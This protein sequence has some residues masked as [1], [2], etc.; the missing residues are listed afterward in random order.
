[1]RAVRRRGAVRCAMHRRVERSSTHACG[2]VEPCSSTLLAGLPAVHA[3]L[4][5]GK[6]AGILVQQPAPRVS[7]FTPSSLLLCVYNPPFITNPLSQAPPQRVSSLF[8]LARP[9][10]HA[11]TVSEMSHIQ[12][13]RQT[14]CAA[15]VAGRSERGSLKPCER[16]G[17]SNCNGGRR[18]DTGR[19]HSAASRA[20]PVLYF[21]F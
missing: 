7:T 3:V 6:Q 4:P 17:E 2:A 19:Q 10:T 14:V 8:T 18:C 5:T 12:A 1:M 11:L 16:E 20:V 15:R 9:H 21:D 13:Y